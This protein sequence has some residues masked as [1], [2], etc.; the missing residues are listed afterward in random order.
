M[1]MPVILIQTLVTLSWFLGITSRLLFLAS[2]LHRSILASA[3]PRKLRLST[4][5]SFFLHP[6]SL[7]LLFFPRNPLLTL[8]SDHHPIPSMLCKSVLSQWRPHC[9]W[10]P[11][12]CFQTC[13][14]FPYPKTISVD[15]IFSSKQ[16]FSL[17]IPELLRLVCSLVPS[18]HTP[19]P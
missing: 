2:C 6:R 5:S 13:S 17:V 9:H 14:R 10:G 7:C 1:S 16:F 19:P 3:V 12:S 15:L 8:G 11:A 4:I 18:F